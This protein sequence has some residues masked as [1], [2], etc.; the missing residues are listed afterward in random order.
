MMEVPLLDLKPQWRALQDE[1]RPVIEDVFSSQ[2]FIMGAGVTAFEADLAAYCRA[3]YAIGVS[4]G[5]DA[6]LAALMALRVGPGDA[7]LTTPFSFF[8]TAGVVSRLGAKPVFADIQPDTFNLDP[9][10]LESAADHRPKQVADTQVRAVIP[11]H[12]YGQCAD[13]D[14]I[15]TVARRR[16]WAVIEDA[17]QSIGADYPSHER[18]RRC[19]GMGDMGC[20][21]FFPSKNLGAAGDAGAVLTNDETL[22]E[23]LRLLRV[24]GHGP[25]GTQPEIGGNFRLDALQAA[26]LKIKLPHLDAW[27]RARAH[28]AQLYH[29]LLSSANIT[30]PD[31]DT[32]EIVLPA[33]RWRESL[34]ADRHAHIFNQFVIR[35]RKRDQLLEFLRAHKVGCAV[36]YPLP[37]HKME[38]FQSL[39]YKPGDFPV[40]ERAAREV[41]ALPVFPELEEAQLKYAAETIVRF[42]QS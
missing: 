14:P 7:V 6:L 20:L 42:Y 13:M 18:V 4:S 35:A 32:A 28:N 10:L 3:Q 2:L 30:G 22:A 34:P 15:M 37:F 33:L 12:L 41:L 16:E 38:C 19:T 24:H 5:T 31:T 25:N 36:Y 17:A 29:E 40:A 21:S 11:V 1:L 8:A 9:N 27:S 23:R 26:Y 39:G